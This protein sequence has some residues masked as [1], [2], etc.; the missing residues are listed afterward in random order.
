MIL[1]LE[2]QIWRHYLI[3]KTAQTTKNDAIN[4]FSKI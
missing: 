2:S 1:K 4:L 3:I